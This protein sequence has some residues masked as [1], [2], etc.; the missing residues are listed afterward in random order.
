[1]FA[2]E[3]PG[4]DRDEIRDWYN[5]YSWLGEENVYNPFDILLLFRQPQVQ[6]AWWFETGTP[7]VSGRNPVPAPRV[8]LACPW[9]TWWAPSDLLSK[10]S[11]SIDIATEA[12]LF[13]TGY[14]TIRPRRAARPGRCIYRLGYP[15][16][17]GS[18]EPEPR[19]F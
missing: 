10:P 7:G 8:E 16:P 9:K 12:L 14:L 4:L 18:A 3:L 5:G 15:E 2:P 11:T 17:G 13:Q 6:G 19:A 1:M